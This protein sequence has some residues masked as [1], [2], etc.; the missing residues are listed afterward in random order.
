MT[1]TRDWRHDAACRTKDP[2]LFFPTGTSGP[3]IAQT[4]Q[5]KAVCHSCPVAS[6]CLTWALQSGQDAGVWGGMSEDER[7]ALKRS[8]ARTRA[9]TS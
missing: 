4:A 7:R 9:R 3:A 1:E 5:A 6:D 2:E 8:N